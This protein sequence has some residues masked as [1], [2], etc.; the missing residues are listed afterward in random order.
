MPETQIVPYNG[1]AG[2]IVPYNGGGGQDLAVQGA[3]AIGQLLLNQ[4]IQKHFTFQLGVDGSHPPLQPTAPEYYKSAS[5]NPLNGFNFY[6][7]G[8]AL[9]QGIID[10]I[11]NSTTCEKAFIASLDK[12]SSVVCDLWMLKGVPAVFAYKVVSQLAPVACNY[13]Y[14]GLT[15]TKPASQIGIERK[16]TS[17]YPFTSLFSQ[18]PL[19]EKPVCHP[20]LQAEVK[21]IL[22][23]IRH[24]TKGQGDLPNLFV[25]GP[26]GTGKTMLATQIIKES[27]LDYI[28]LSGGHLTQ[29]IA[30]K[31]HVTELNKLFDAVTHTGRP[32][33]L[34]IDEAEGAIK[35]RNSIDQDHLELLDTLLHWTGTPKPNIMLICVA[36]ECT[37]IDRAFL[38]R[39]SHRLKMPLPS[40]E[41]RQEI[42]NQ[43]SAALFKDLQETLPTQLIEQIAQKTEGFSGRDLRYLTGSL[44]DVH[45]QYGFDNPLRQANIHRVIEQFIAARLNKPPSPV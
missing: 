12:I 19:I 42:L 30:T 38:S 18:E 29:W 1:G 20:L 26:P 8:K 15:D 34:L 33:I 6:S 23:S 41:E 21:S 45:T 27:S 35:H 44:H 13:I 9:A 16:K 36:N 22:F 10:A 2:Q 4:Q 28:A 24:A 31:Q 5:Y 11:S 32:T 39:M 3:M 37:N 7:S 14:H 25:Y 40:I 17:L 43:Q